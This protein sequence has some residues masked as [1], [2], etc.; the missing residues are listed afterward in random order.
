MNKLIHK[1]Q[2]EGEDV[3]GGAIGGNENS[4]VECGKQLVKWW[5]AQQS[6]QRLTVEMRS[7]KSHTD[8]CHITAAPQSSSYIHA[9]SNVEAI[10]ELLVETTQ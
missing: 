6:T 1:Y 7:F 4:S 3:G 5:L 8:L 9:L 10:V 2:A